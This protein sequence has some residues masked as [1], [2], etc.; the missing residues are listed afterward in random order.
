MLYISLGFLSGNQTLSAE[1][2]HLTKMCKTSQKK[3]IPASSL[4]FHIVR[5]HI[6]TILQ[7]THAK[8]GT[9]FDFFTIKKTRINPSFRVD[10][11]FIGYSC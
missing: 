10:K 6:I 8:I 2:R 4:T 11:S 5:L 7:V 3:K 9:A 1:A